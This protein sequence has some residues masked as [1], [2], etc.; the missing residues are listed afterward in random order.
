MVMKTENKEYDKKI[1]QV[2]QCVVVV[3]FLEESQRIC[4]DLTAI[5]SCRDLMPHKLIPS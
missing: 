4:T 3:V 2:S 1:G 5:A